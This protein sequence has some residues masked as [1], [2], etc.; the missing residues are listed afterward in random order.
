MSLSVTVGTAVLSLGWV[1]RLWHVDELSSTWLQKLHD[2]SELFDFLDISRT[3]LGNS[4]ELIIGKVLCRVQCLVCEVLR[5]FVISR[6]VLLLLL[7]LGDLGCALLVLKL[8][9]LI[10]GH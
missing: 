3:L 1:S 9:L 2:R 8:V 4:F 10:T 6:V 5:R 7:L